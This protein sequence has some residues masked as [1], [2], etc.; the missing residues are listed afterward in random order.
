[1]R[2]KPHPVATGLVMPFA[3]LKDSPAKILL[4]E[5]AKWEVRPSG[6]LV[7]KRSSD[8]GAAIPTIRLR[9][10]HGSICHEISISSQATFG[11]LKKLLAART[12]LHPL[13]QKITFKDR[14]RDSA[15]FLDMS[16]VKNRSKMAVVED[17]AA[18]A[19]RLLE[20]RR[21]VK[22]ERAT[23]SIS[24]IRLEVDKLAFQV[25]ALETVIFNGGKVAENEVARLIE[26]LMNELLK[27]D[28]VA[29]DGDVK[30]QRSAQVRRV[31]SYVETLDLIMLKNTLPKAYNGQARPPEQQTKKQ[32]PPFP[33]FPS[34]IVTT[35]RETFHSLFSPRTS[36]STSAAAT[37]ASSTAASSTTPTPRLDWELF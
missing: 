35:K 19:K 5:P 28:G 32:S 21:A 15:A 8:E 3:P 7:Q 30:L 9:V 13:D 1:M 26:L 24:Q 11:E 16:G 34:A 20:V 10:K 22:M 36:A 37:T 31:Q 33:Q 23:K 29:V 14:E 6:M 18:Q 2:T 12:G 27:L 4:N 25:S 17:P